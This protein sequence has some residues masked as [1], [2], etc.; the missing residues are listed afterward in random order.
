LKKTNR[1][2]GKNTAKQI[3]MKILIAPQ[4]WLSN[5]AIRRPFMVE[6]AR[7]V[8]SSGLRR[9]AKKSKKTTK[10]LADW[11]KEEMSFFIVTE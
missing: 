9:K 6:V 5:C 3:Q 7:P 10:E 4:K 1:Q 2:G 8:E 11:L